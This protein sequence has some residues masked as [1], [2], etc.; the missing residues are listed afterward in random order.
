VWFIPF[1]YNF[2]NVDADKTGFYR[3]RDEALEA[4]DIN[5]YKTK[6]IIIEV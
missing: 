6:H 1:W 5:R 2:N 4:I 3:T